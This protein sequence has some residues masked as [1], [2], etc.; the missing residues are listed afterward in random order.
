MYKFMRKILMVLFVAA[1]FISVQAQQKD[2]PVSELPKEVKTVLDEYVNILTT[3]KDLDE[4]ANRFISVAGGTLVNPAGNALRSSVKPYSL[5]KDYN[6]IKYY[7]VPVEI[8]RV[9]KTRTQQCGYGASAIA[10]DWYKIYIVKKDG[11]Q[12]AP[13]QIV[14]PEN[15]PNVTTPKVMSIGSL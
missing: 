13:I 11:S 6:D 9:A 7:K 2:I 5:K 3:S 8:A 12:P 14:V 1:S 10:G 15:N 4:C